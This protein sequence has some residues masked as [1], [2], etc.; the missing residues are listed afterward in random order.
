MKEEEGGKWPM[1]TGFLVSCVALLLLVIV[2]D[3]LV[4]IS[5]AR[6]AVAF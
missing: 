4:I 5:A 2:S 1:V 3:S 6:R